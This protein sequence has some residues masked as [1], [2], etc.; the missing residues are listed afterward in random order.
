MLR[1]SDSPW[2]SLALAASCVH[3]ISWGLF[4]IGLPLVAARA[5]GFDEPPSE[6][7]LW[8]GVGLVICLFGIGYGIAATDPR[9]HWA[10]VLIG[11]LAKVLGPIG[12]VTA[13]ARGEVASGVLWL[14]PVNDIIWWIPF[15]VVIAHGIRSDDRSRNR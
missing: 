11:L 4:I 7:F 12:I 1:N 9:R 6:L 15:G 14:L 8:Q 5:Y 3:S 2:L 13:V 10:A